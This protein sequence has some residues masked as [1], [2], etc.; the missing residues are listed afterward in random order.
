[1]L[2]IDSDDER[3]AQIKPLLQIVVNGD[4]EFTTEPIGLVDPCR[5]LGTVTFADTHMPAA[6]TRVHTAGSETN[7]GVGYG[8]TK[9]DGAGHFVLGRLAAGRYVV[10]GDSSGFPDYAVAAAMVTPSASEA[11]HADLVMVHGGIV[12]GVARDQATGKGLANVSV[13]LYGP[14]RPR[15]AAEIEGRTTDGGGAG[16]DFACLR[17]AQYVYLSSEQ[18][19]E[20][21]VISGAGNITESVVP[22]GRE[23][24][25]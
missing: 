16:T 8:E 12:T 4:A 9:T 13:G 6:N 23:R 17:G 1:M 24:D 20:G 11:A 21:Y 5:I 3:Y 14:S 7:N 22:R 10:Y 15:E 25:A 19:P 18:P 2:K